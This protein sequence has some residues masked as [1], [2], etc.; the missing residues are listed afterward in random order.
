MNDMI[1][2]PFSDQQLSD[3]DNVTELKTDTNVDSAGLKLVKTR[4]GKQTEPCSSPLL[5][6]SPLPLSSLLLPLSLLTPLSSPIPQIDL[7][8]YNS[9]NNSSSN[10]SISTPV[11]M[12]SKSTAEVTHVG[13]NKLPILSAGMVSLEVLRQFENACCSFFRKK[14]GPGAQGLC[15]LYCGQTS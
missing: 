13:S 9:S 2:V 7:R 1:N 10:I 3:N 8:H 4:S 5:P 6:S 11:K 15:H 12:S 14:R